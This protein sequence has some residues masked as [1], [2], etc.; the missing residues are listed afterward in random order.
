M[1]RFPRRAR[2]LKPDEFKAA[3]ENGRRI[4]DTVLAA[5]TCSNTLGHAR[6]GLAV[7]KKA[8]PLATDRNRIKRQ[9]RASFRLNQE[10]LQTVDIVILPRPGILKATRAEL[11][12][13]LQRLW[14][15]FAS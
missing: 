14:T 10:R 2:L 15:R 4:N 1:T 7:A 9:V 8:V 11:S 12:A 6:L 13:S 3:F 5:V